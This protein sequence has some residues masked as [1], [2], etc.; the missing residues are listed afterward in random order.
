MINIY[1]VKETILRVQNQYRNSD[2]NLD[3]TDNDLDHSIF[4]EVFLMENG[5][6]RAESPLNIS[7][8]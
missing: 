7:V 2:N 3:H 1:K 5:W 8:L 4:L 6:R